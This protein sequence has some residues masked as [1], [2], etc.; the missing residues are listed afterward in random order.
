MPIIPMWG[1]LI[2]ETWNESKYHFFIGNNS[3]CQNQRLTPDSYI[4]YTE[5]PKSQEACKQC[6][7]ELQ[8]TPFLR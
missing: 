2:G 4:T 5:I 1:R 7:N 3:A 8:K 6:I